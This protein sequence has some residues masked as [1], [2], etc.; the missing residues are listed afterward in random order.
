MKNLLASALILLAGLTAGAASITIPEAG[1]F[2]R[3]RHASGL[4]LTDAGFGATVTESTDGGKQIFTF[5]PVE[6]HEGVYNIRRCISGNYIGSDG[7]W[8]TSA[9]SRSIPMSQFRIVK[10]DDNFVKFQN[11][12]MSDA[13]SFLG[14]DANNSGGVNS[15]VYTDKN[16]S[17]ASLHYWTI[18]PAE[19]YVAPATPADVYPDRQLADDDPR[20][21][22]YEGYKL[23]FAQEFSGEGK[24]D[25]E[26]WNFEKGFKRNNEDQY[27]N[28]DKNCVIRD[29]VLVISAENVADQKIK[30]PSYDKYNKA[31]PSNIGRYLTWTS[32]SMQTKGPW[33]GGYS[34][35]FGIYE[36]RAKLEQVVGSWP[37]IWSTGKAHE[38]PYGGEIDILEYYGR[39]IHANVCWGDGKRWSAKWNS[40]T[41]GDNNLP[42]DFSDTYH[43]WRMVWDYDHMELWCDD[44]LVNNIDLDT[45]Q[46]AKYTDGDI[47]DGD[48]CNPFR[49]VRQM[50]WLNMAMGGDNGGSLANT[51]SPCRFLVDY[52]RVYQKIGTDG[53]ATYS[54]DDVISEPSFPYK[55]GEGEALGIEDV[56]ADGPDRVKGVYNLQGIFVAKNLDSIQPSGQVLI[57]VSDHGSR[58]VVH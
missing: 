19:A 20:A 24:P 27:Y 3:I 17:D 29:G 13:K 42:A 39:K 26:I 2:Y 15:G 44:M 6:G 51:P 33:D 58:K 54:V 38:W 53:N 35:L 10:V 16:G 45:T 30:N 7:K 37:A 21:H 1:Q 43:I 18:E 49:D 14:C 23:V 4:Y 28:D 22:A 50:L 11:L 47:D 52:C 25:P 36:I 48:G 55:N 5:V 40:A 31:W 9:I 46:N 32:G 56:D 8:S 41:I 12:G 34:W 57:E